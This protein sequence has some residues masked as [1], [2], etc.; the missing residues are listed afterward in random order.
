MAA[1]EG[2]L[3]AAGA[4]VAVPV[5]LDGLDEILEPVGCDPEAEDFPE[6]EAEAATEL[7]VVMEGVTDAITIMLAL[8]LVVEE[9][10]HLRAADDPEDPPAA[11]VEIG[12]E[13][14]T[15]L[16]EL[17]ATAAPAIDATSLQLEDAG[18][19]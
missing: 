10:S 11:V 7:G 4:P 18:A 3:V 9:Q 8:I 1:E 17:D 16:A 5:P 6:A 14:V 15:P 19:G 13:D 12:G 2:E